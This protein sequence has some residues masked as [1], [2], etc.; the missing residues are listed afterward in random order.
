MGF[1]LV[2]G[3]WFVVRS[4]FTT[5]LVLR[6]VNSL[7][8]IV[9]YTSVA[10]AANY[11]QDLND[12]IKLEIKPLG[13][14]DIVIDNLNQMNDKHAGLSEINLSVLDNDWRSEL[15]K[16]KQPLIT[17]VMENDLSKFLIKTVEAGQ[18]V[19][20]EI[21]VI[22]SR[23][24]NIGQTVVS[25]NYFNAGKPRWDKTF[26]IKSYAPYISDI[27]FSDETNKFQ[28]EVSLM[29]ISD[30]KPIGIVAAGIDVEQL[31]DWKK[32]RK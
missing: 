6:T 14:S 10:Q 24:L 15:R 13:S 32:R 8:L 3:L 28:V 23:G 29:I 19:Y 11:S 1:K 4:F 7:F 9:L 21:T 22:D 2:G 5:N 20:T 12:F 18:G 16:I 25:Q 17:Q 30:E 26:A 31:E 27:Y